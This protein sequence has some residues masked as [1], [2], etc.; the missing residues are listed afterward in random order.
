MPRMRVP[1]AAARGKAG[2]RHRRATATAL[3]W[4]S[5]DVRFRAGTN[6]DGSPCGLRLPSTTPRSGGR[7]N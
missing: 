2:V 5:P 4:A 3:N 7:A 1:C 6:A